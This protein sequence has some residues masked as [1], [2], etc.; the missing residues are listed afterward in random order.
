MDELFEKCTHLRVLM[1]ESFESMDG[2]VP[3]SMGDLVQLRHLSFKNARVEGLPR[4]SCN[5]KWAK[6]L[7][8][9]GK[10]RTQIS[11]IRPCCP[12]KNGRAETFG[13]P[14]TFHHR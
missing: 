1:L 14:S 4:S 12:A 7:D 13:P 8:L 6:T 10:M 11:S 5:L 2:F 9:R 3:R